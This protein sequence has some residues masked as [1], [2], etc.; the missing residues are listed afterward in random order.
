VKS[1]RRCVDLHELRQLRVH[2]RGRHRSRTGAGVGRRLEPLPLSPYMH[3]DPLYMS[4]RTHSTHMDST[5]PKDWVSISWDQ[6]SH[7][8]SLTVDGHVI[9]H[10][11]NNTVKFGNKSSIML[12]AT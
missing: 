5:D 7:C 10:W 12:A 4:A 6:W 11:K 1:H 8:R 9:F 3:V 2:R